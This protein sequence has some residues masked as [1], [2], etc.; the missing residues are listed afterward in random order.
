[1]RFLADMGISPLTV[2]YLQEM[3]HE[4]THLHSLGLDEMSDSD[5]LQKAQC[6]D[7]ILLTHDLDFGEL[8]ALR[9]A[10]MPSVITFRMRDMTPGNVNRYLRQIL[11]QHTGVLSTGC[12]MTVSERRIRVHRL[13][14]HGGE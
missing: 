5:I 9:R 11:E 13:P 6:E 8:L 10:L 3:G 1:M 4:A 7:A 14:L 12:A 2:R